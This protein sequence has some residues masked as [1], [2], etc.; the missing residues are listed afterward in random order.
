M[1]ISQFVNDDQYGNGKCDMR[2]SKNKQK[3]LKTPTTAI[4][5]ANKE[6]TFVSSERDTQKATFDANK[7]TD[8]GACIDWIMFHVVFIIYIH[9]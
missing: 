3:F 9:T 5:A 2:W 1:N 7:S 6:E 8:F 4:I